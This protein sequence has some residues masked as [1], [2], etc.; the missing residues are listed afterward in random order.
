MPPAEP[1]QLIAREKKLL[2]FREGQVAACE[3]SVAEVQVKSI[4]SPAVRFRLLGRTP[5]PYPGAYMRCP[6]G[7]SV[8][9]QRPGLH[10]IWQPRDKMKWPPP[11]VVVPHDPTPLAVLV[12]ENSAIERAAPQRPS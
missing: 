8:V 5:R 3:G 7:V 6:C 4:S 11:I 12:A 1:P 10:R 9:H 2:A